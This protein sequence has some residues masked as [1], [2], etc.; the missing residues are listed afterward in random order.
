MRDSDPPAVVGMPASLHDTVL[1]RARF[2]SRSPSP[3]PRPRSKTPKTPSTKRSAD[4]TKR[5]STSAPKLKSK[6]QVKKHDVDYV[7]KKHMSRFR[8]CY[9]KELAKDS[10]LQGKISIR[11]AI[12]KKGNVAEMLKQGGTAMKKALLDLYNAVL[13]P[14]S[15]PPI[16]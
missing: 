11:F 5:S 3:S 16:S 10:D 8:L 9:Q 15:P 1:P 12:N 14:T 13:S 6:G 2:N 4:S 7:I